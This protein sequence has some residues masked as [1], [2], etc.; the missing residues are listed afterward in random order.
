MKSFIALAAIAAVNAAPVPAPC[1][2]ADVVDTWTIVMDGAYLNTQR[3]RGLEGEEEEEDNGFL[4]SLR[5]LLKGG[6]PKPKPKESMYNEIGLI[7]LMA[8]GKFTAKSWMSMGKTAKPMTYAGNWTLDFDECEVLIMPGQGL[9][10]AGHLSAGKNVIQGIVW[11]SNNYAT[12]WE[13]KRAATGCTKASLAGKWQFNGVSEY[14][15]KPVAYAGKDTAN[16]NGKFTSEGHLS[17]KT[18]MNEFMTKGNYTVSS[19]CTFT[20][21]SEDGG[22][23]VSVMHADKTTTFMNMNAP[24][25]LGEARATL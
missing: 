9:T 21:A 12:K 6:K 17:G 15:G 5:R 16:A 7:N 18:K 23:Y 20:R 11:N 8:N 4:G 10:L 13:A 22:R 1:T 2:K 3:G 24:G 19:D 25:E 14:G